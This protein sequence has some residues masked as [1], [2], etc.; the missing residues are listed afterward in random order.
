V[1]AIRRV[2][3]RLRDAATNEVYGHMYTT[4]SNP[5]GKYVVTQ[6]EF[7]AARGGVIAVHAKCGGGSYVETFW[8][9]WSMLYINNMFLKA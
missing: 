8:V 6:A 5:D 2:D 3:R 9:S 4:G 7:N 1:N